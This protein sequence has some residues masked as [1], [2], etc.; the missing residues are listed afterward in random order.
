MC[1]VNADVFPGSL[2][3][4]ND[5]V[6][7]M[8]VT[9]ALKLTQSGLSDSDSQSVNRTTLFSLSQT[10]Y[11]SNPIKSLLNLLLQSLAS[12]PQI[13]QSIFQTNRLEISSHLGKPPPKRKT[14]YSEPCHV[15]RGEKCPDA[16]RM[17]ALKYRVRSDLNTD[18]SVFD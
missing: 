8:I 13:Y 10:N 14:V 6:V 12:I 1:R 11:H 16:S 18:V 9:D 4:N 3:S 17:F 5:I 2:N 15:L 7:A